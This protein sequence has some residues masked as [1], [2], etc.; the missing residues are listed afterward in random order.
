MS[1]GELIEFFNEQTDRIKG[2]MDE[3]VDSLHMQITGSSNIVRP[4]SFSIYN[5]SGDVLFISNFIG[6]Y[7]LFRWAWWITVYSKSP[8]KSIPGRYSTK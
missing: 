1:R 6:P 5:I 2:L 3:M 8:E 4:V 7:H